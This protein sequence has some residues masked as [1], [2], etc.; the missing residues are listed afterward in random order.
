[1]FLNQECLSNSMVTKKTKHAQ[2]FEGTLQLRNHTQEVLDWVLNKVEKDKRATIP[3][4][5]RVRG[6]G[7]DLQFSDQHY[8]QALAKQMKKKWVAEVKISHRLHTQSHVTSK[9]LYRVTVLFRMLNFKI[10][11]VVDVDGEPLEVIR[12]DKQVHTKNKKTGKKQRFKI[13][14]FVR[15]TR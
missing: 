5:S 11:D 9:K 4:A 8:L 1:M 6:G 12:V 3:K 15:Y 14:D 2:Y 7:L 13:D 10:G